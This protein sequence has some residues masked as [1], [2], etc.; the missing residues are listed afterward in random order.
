M[1]SAIVFLPLVGALIAGF[2]GR[3][4]GDRGAQIV[5]CGAMAASSILAAVAFWEVAI[6][7]RSFTV[8]VL[9]WVAS[10]SF[11]ANW[12]LRWDT[13]TAVMVLVVTVV[14]TMVHVYSVGYMSHD[15]SIP[16]FMAYLS[17]HETIF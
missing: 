17:I 11:E 7:G 8:D 12:A 2:G 3:I 13:L 1:Y 4:I 9:T 14:S 15:H 5:T 6:G 16:R 10:G